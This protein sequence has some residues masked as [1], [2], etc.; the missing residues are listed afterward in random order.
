MDPNPPPN[1]EFL[2]MRDHQDVKTEKINE[3]NLTDL[4]TDATKEKKDF[5]KNP[6]GVEL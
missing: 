2:E 1:K 4:S 5:L 3:S 6:N